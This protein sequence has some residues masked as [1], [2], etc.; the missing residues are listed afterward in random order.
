ME[1]VPGSEGGEDGDGSGNSPRRRQPHPGLFAFALR[2][3]KEQPTDLG[4]LPRCGFAARRRK[5][6]TG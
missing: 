2:Q 5:R 6:R 1:P 4:R 3:R